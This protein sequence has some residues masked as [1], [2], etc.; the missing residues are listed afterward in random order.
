MSSAN[1]CELGKDVVRAPETT[2][3]LFYPEAKTISVGMNLGQYPP[4]HF[5][6]LLHLRSPIYK[7]DEIKLL[8]IKLSEGARRAGNSWTTQRRG[9]PSL[10]EAVSSPWMW[11]LI[12]ASPFDR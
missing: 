10:G 4:P 7:E 5:K 8:W 11:Y 2:K 6:A 9:R 1:K 12:L 3:S